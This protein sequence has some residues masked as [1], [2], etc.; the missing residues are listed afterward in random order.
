[1]LSASLLAYS[2]P[3]AFASCAPGRPRNSVA[4]HVV[5]SGSPSGING[6]SAS[7]F[8]YDPYYSGNNPTGT[9]MS[10]MLHNG[11]GLWAQIGWLKHKVGST[12]KREVFMETTDGSGHQFDNYLTGRPVGTFTSYEIT[13][14]ASSHH[15]DYWEN[16][17]DVESIGGN[18]SPNEYQVFGETHDLEDQMPGGTGNVAV[19]NSVDARTGSS[20]THVTPVPWFDNN[21]GTYFGA[22]DSSNFF[23][24]DKACSS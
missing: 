4:Y 5:I 6:I 22:S 13:F 11:G 8:E 2:V 21:G 9:N 23:L 12:I 16:G 19:F 18:W 3:V 20:W 14:T 15:F 24:W 7:A 17:T 1:M 10:V